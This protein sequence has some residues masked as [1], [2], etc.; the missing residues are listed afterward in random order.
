MLKRFLL[1]SLAIMLIATSATTASVLLFFDQTVAKFTHVDTGRELTAVTG[2]NPQTVMIA[3]SDRRYGD[4]K[5][6]L[7]ARS[8]TIMLVRIDPDKGVALLSLPR[9]GSARSSTFATATRTPTSSATRASRT[10]C[11][12]SASS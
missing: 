7:K 11:A 10:S 3:G 12:R 4:K 1:G 5:L 8:D 2:G 9:E 6:G